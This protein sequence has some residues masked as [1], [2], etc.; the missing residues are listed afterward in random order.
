MASRD[1]DTYHARRQR[2]ARHLACGCRER[3]VGGLAHEQAFQDVAGALREGAD[4]R[5]AVS[6]A[7]QGRP[8]ART[9]APKRVSGL[10]EPYCKAL[11]SRRAIKG[12]AS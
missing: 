5:A 4:L 7:R 12:S 11:I 3:R 8:A 2:R 1:G 10:S 6:F 9:S